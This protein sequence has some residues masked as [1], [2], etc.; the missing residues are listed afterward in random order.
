MTVKTTDKA[1]EGSVT[2]V[3]YHL[4]LYLNITRRP[5]ASRGR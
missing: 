4:P 5:R 2:M 1:I 3:L